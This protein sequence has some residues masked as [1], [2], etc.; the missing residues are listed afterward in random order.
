M[1]TMGK[2]GKKRVSA[3]VEIKNDNMYIIAE[4]NDVAV[5][6]MELWVNPFSALVQKTQEISLDIYTS[7]PS[8]PLRS[9]QPQNSRTGFI[10]GIKTMARRRRKIPDRDTDSHVT[11]V[12]FDMTT[13]VS[14]SAGMKNFGP[15]GLY[16]APKVS[17]PYYSKVGGLSSNDPKIPSKNLRPSKMLIKEMTH[18]DDPK[19]WQLFTSMTDPGYYTEVFSTTGLENKYYQLIYREHTDP[20][21]I[22][23]FSFPVDTPEYSFDGTRSAD[24]RSDIS[25]F[26]T[27][28]K[29]NNRPIPVKPFLNSQLNTDFLP[30]RNAISNDIRKTAITRKNQASHPSGAQMVIPQFVPFVCDVTVPKSAIY[31]S[32]SLFFQF[33]LRRKN[34][35]I[36]QAIKTSVEMQDKLGNFRRPQSPPLL[37]VKSISPG[38]TRVQVRQNDLAASEILV[39][40][41]SISTLNPAASTYTR[42]LKKSMTVRDG[43]YEFTDNNNSDSPI[44]Y[45]AI[46]MNSS[47]YGQEI[48]SAVSVPRRSQI[49]RVSKVSIQETRAVMCARSVEEGVEIEV[50]LLQTPAVSCYVIAKDVT[51]MTNPRLG[52]LKDRIVGDVKNQI[53]ECRGTGLET[54]TFLDHD[55][56]IGRKYVYQLK[57]ITLMGDHILSNAFV[58]HEHARIDAS[59]RFE[60]KNIKE[61]GVGN[62][63]LVAMDLN[64][65]QQAGDLDAGLES[66]VSKLQ[67]S[68]ASTDFLENIKTNRQEYLDLISFLVVRINMETGIKDNFGVVPA[69][70]F[71]DTPEVRDRLG[72][73]DPDPGVTYRYEVTVLRRSPMTLFKGLVEDEK[74]GQTLANFEKDFRKFQNPVTLKTSTT[75][76]ERI[77]DKTLKSSILFDS[78]EFIQGKTSTIRTHISNGTKKQ[79]PTLSKPMSSIDRGNTVLSWSVE[80]GDARNI[81]HFLIFCTYKGLSAPVGTL[82]TFSPGNTYSFIDKKLSGAIGRKVYNI[83]P[84]LNNFKFGNISDDVSV[85][86]GMNLDPMEI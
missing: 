53:Q 41:K 62:T 38:V 24:T 58:E 82:H 54:N 16:L 86:T 81:D 14:N 5:L 37:M 72:I 34:G 10:N 43:S 55:A 46:S 6:R 22:F 36:A 60:I 4:N 44:L 73:A 49:N 69:G 25:T 13:L 85:I 23:D 29:Y 65:S 40:K 59:I 8:Q 79:G 15:D 61:R 66:L 33:F 26:H 30:A 48:A 71:S 63:K 9:P 19:Q 17:L 74:D 51:G 47:L 42:V 7:D 52:M 12:S 57:L 31:E 27:L 67:N 21:S 50:D 35:S 56:L 39:F 70:T 20:I 18:A 45:R 2:S 11:N 1:L 32:S 80:R 64:A 78:N 84:V 3:L 76:P 75:P 28:E 83:I 77:L 68:G